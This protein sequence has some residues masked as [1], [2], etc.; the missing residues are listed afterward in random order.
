[1]RFIAVAVVVGLATGLGGSALLPR[2]RLRH[3]REMQ[4][5]WWPALIVGLAL[6]LPGGRLDSAAGTVLLVVAYGM[7]LAFALANLHVAGMGLVALG[8]SLNVTTIAVNGGMPVRA[9]AAVAAGIVPPDDVATVG[10]DGKR[11]LERADDR[12]MV[13]SDVIPVPSLS[14]VVSPGDIVM[15]VG[16]AVVLA[17]LLRRRRAAAPS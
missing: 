7:L 16:L 13:I 5:R 17:N 15:A 6:Q 9:D 3:A 4:L 11:H 8:I 14:E 2:R 12:L 1:M 10:F